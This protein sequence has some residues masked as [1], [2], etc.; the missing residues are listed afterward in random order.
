[1]SA[2]RAGPGVVRDLIGRHAGLSE[3]LL[4][5]LEQGGC[6]V[7]VGS[8]D[9]AALGAIA[10]GGAGLNRQLIEREMRTGER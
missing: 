7:F 3:P 2:F 4:R 6:G 10:E 8:K 9:F 1:M 5:D